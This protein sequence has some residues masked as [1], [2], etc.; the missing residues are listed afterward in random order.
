MS[1]PL[2]PPQLFKAVSWKKKN[3]WN[4]RILQYI[5]LNFDKFWFMIFAVSVCHLKTSI[6]FFHLLKMPTMLLFSWS[7]LWV[8]V[9]SWLCCTQ[10]ACL[11]TFRG[12]VWNVVHDKVLEWQS[13]AICAVFFKSLE[14]LLFHFL[15]VWFQFQKSCFLCQANFNDKN[16]GS[17]SLYVNP[18]I[19]VWK[20]LRV[21]CIKKL[22]HSKIFHGI[23]IARDALF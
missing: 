21:R 3:P 6:G 11:C 17:P 19:Q 8:C 13:R 16:S 14:K 9:R 12:P 18:D 22:H 4:L 1:L 15:A 10:G 7:V 2:S 23:H 5:H 20:F